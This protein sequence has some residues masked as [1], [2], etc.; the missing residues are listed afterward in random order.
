MENLKKRK[1]II[2]KRKSNSSQ[3]PTELHF[4]WYIHSPLMSQRLI[5]FLKFKF[6][7]KKDCVIT[8]DEFL[9]DLGG[10]K[11]IYKELHEV[12]EESLPNLNLIK[13]EDWEYVLKKMNKHSRQ[14]G[15]V[16]FDSNGKIEFYDSDPFIG[17][18]HAMPVDKKS[19]AE[20]IKSYK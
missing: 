15:F 10:G 18:V 7:N 14:Y 16:D 5:N 19:I 2:D 6:E 8:D 20:I 9:N 3:I 1:T 11:K 13:K 17:G 12:I 4:D